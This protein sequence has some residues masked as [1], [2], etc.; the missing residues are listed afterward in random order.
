MKLNFLK[1]LFGRTLTALILFFSFA[2]ATIQPGKD[3]SSVGNR[4][5]QIGIVASLEQSL[6]DDYKSKTFPQS[7]CSRCELL[8]LS[9]YGADGKIQRERIAEA[10]KA[11]NTI[12]ILFFQFNSP[13]DSQTETW[14]DQL[15]RLANQGTVVIGVAGLAEDAQPT[16]PLTRTFLGSVPHVLILGERN[17]RD[18][19]PP[20]SFFGPPMLTALKVPP[21]NFILRLARSWDQKDSPAQW[22]SYFETKKG[23]SKKTWLDLND[24]F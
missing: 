24:L 12:D 5:I 17:H 8:N 14:R 13:L 16:L 2:E 7:Q 18:L 6:F 9:P 4:K 19:L 20:R 21:E 1:C 11:I 10:L 23:K 3:S 15:A 22:V